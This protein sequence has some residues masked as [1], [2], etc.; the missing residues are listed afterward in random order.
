MFY[1]SV[2]ERRR[3]QWELERLKVRLQLG[4]VGRAWAAAG[5]RQR[6]VGMMRHYVEGAS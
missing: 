2:L 1:R 5:A 6:A 3:S 4:D